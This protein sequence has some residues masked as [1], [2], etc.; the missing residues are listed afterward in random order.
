MAAMFIDSWMGAVFANH[1]DEA[2]LHLLFELFVC[3][4]GI[5]LVYGACKHLSWV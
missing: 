5:Y 1:L 4:L 2:L 3:S